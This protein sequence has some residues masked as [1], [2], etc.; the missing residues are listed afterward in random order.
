MNYQGE[1][2]KRKR[3][4]ILRRDGYMCQLSKRYG[5][6]KEAQVVHHI[7][8]AE[9]YPQYQWED[10]NLISITQEMHNQL[11]DRNTNK[12]TKKG[13]ELLQRTARKRRISPPQ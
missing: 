7:F 4:K 5:Q 2:W 1:R 10:W 8:P 13:L 9:D 6:M 11:H 3:E 12:L